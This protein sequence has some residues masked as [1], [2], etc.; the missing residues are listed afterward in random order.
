PRYGY[1]RVHTLLRREGWADGLN[2]VHRLYRLE[3]LHVRL[4]VKKKRRAVVRVPPTQ[5]TAPNERPAIDFPY[6]TLH[7]GR[8]FRVLP[9]VDT[10]SRSCVALEVGLGFRGSTV[11]GALERAAKGKLPKTIP[12]D[13][14][15]EFTSKAFDAWAFERGV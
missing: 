13:N 9:V 10:F 7:A 5:A 12:A 11:A 4:K 14:G 6:D 3:G 2:R 1:R 15:T 8:P